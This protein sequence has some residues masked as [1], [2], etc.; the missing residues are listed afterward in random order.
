MV[1]TVCLGLPYLSG[2]NWARRKK[3]CLR[4]LRTTKVKTCICKCTDGSAH[5]YLQF[6][7]VSYLNLLQVK[8]KFSVGEE[9]MPPDKAA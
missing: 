7:K 9:A 6:G 8:F 1:C 5:C 3:T 4:G 2:F